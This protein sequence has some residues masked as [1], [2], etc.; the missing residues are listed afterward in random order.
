M[1]WLFT[2]KKEIDQI[3]NSTK[4]GFES[5]RKDVN[6]VVGWIKHLDSENNLRQREIEEIK[7]I[8]H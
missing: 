3:K 8:L 1:F 6:S 7:E 2:K 5:V 4:Q